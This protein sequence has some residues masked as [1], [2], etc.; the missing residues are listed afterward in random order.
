M[1]V[2]AS[3]RQSRV[4]SGATGGGSLTTGDDKAGVAND[5][6]RLGRAGTAPWL[7]L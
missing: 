1:G 4:E 3:W 2:E 5:G 7:S 6:E